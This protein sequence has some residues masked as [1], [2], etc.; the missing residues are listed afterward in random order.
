[1]ANNVLVTGGAGY[2]GSHTTLQLVENGH[3][4]VVLDNLYSGHEWA[5]ADRARFYRGDIH[6]R[7]LI[8]KIISDHYIDSIIHFAGHIV[9]PESVENPSKYYDNNVLGSLNLI[10]SSIDC[11][12]R[13]FVFSSSAAVYGIPD[14]SPVSEDTLLRPINPYG[15]TKL[16]TEWTL[17]DLS[18]AAK[19]DFG[20]VALRYFNVAGAHMGGQL[21]QSTPNATH[22]I[23]VACQTATAQ[24][25]NMAVFGDDYDTPDGSCIRDYIHVDDLA[26][27]HLCALDY[28][29]QGGKSDIFNCGYGQGFSVKQVI[30][31]VKQL[32]NVD[33]EA[34][35]QPRRP[36]D[37]PQLIANNTKIKQAFHWNPK[38]DDLATICQSA[39]QWE[40]KLVSAG[41]SQ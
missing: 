12:I 2:I 37:P 35:I 25:Q 8:A 17:N 11:G 20:Y 9:V 6:D 16:I 18:L 10:Q 5:I 32:S 23:K 39:L 41:Q 33:F 36:G 38:Y 30:D 21:G 26:S 28:L 13:N 34:N 29:D 40:R 7:D 31:C 27:A 14:H 1:M 4:V 24:R 22:L 3:N 15:S 19:K